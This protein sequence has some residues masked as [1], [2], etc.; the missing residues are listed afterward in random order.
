MVV[1]VLADGN[2]LMFAL[3]DLGVDVGRGGLCRLLGEFAE[4]T[5]LAV[6]VVYDGGAPEG[7]LA[8]QLED[9]RIAVWYGQDRPADEVLAEMIAAHSAPRRL[10]V[11]SSDRAVRR[12][13]RARRCRLADSGQFARRLIEPPPAPS[14]PA[15]PPGKCAGLTGQQA[16]EWLK[17]FGL[18]DDSTRDDP[19]ED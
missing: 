14:P 15:E 19:R 5:G 9:R 4:A 6:A 2:N 8:Q 3:R 17:A 12:A 11:V 18:D 1:R 13:A 10:T 7:P 16:R